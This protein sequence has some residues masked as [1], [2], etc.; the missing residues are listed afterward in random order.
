MLRRSG[1]SILVAIAGLVLLAAFDTSFAL[2]K[3]EEANLA[4]M[5]PGTPKEATASE[6][7]EAGD[8]AVWHATSVQ[9]NRAY[10]V[11]YSDMP[12]AT[13]KS[14]PNKM[15]IGARDG[16]GRSATSTAMWLGLLSLLGCVALV[17]S[18][19]WLGLSIFPDL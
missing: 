9:A 11:S 14:D 5:M 19:L 17:A 6:K 18:M 7:T 3:K 12:K 16:A 8:I 10:Y 4:V 15:L 1:P 13:W 2:Y